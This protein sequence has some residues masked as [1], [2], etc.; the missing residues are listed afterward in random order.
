MKR[1]HCPPVLLSA[2]ATL[3]LSGTALAA[4]HVDIVATGLNNPRGLNFAPN[5]ELYV[6]EAGSGGDGRCIPAPDDPSAQTLL[7]GNGCAHHHL[8][9]GVATEKSRAP[10]SMAGPGGFAASS[11]PVD[12][13]F[14]GM[15]AFVCH[16]LGRRPCPALRR[17]QKRSAF[18]HSATST[19]RRHIRAGGRHFRR[20][21]NDS[22]QPAGRSTPIRMAPLRCQA[23]AS[24]DAGANCADRI[25]RLARRILPRARSNTCGIAA[26]GRRT[27]GVP[28]TVVEGPDGDLMWGTHGS[29][30]PARNF[31]Y[32]LF[33]P[34]GGTPEVYLAGLTAVVDIAFD[35]RG[36]LYILEIAS[37]LQCW[38]ECRSGCRKRTPA[39]QAARC[40]NR[41]RLARQP[42]VSKW[43]C[44][45]TGQRV[46]LTNYGIFPDGGEVLRG[47]SR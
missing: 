30:V 31:K 18:R 36:D 28:T 22:I 20:M 32:L 14:I 26:D 4:T 27:R 21:R 35:R 15:S 34:Q 46:Y 16:G 1:L 24:A 7:W 38:A 45:R 9:G 11:G 42:R 44:D 8:S 40:R 6:A 17:R 23:G 2:F 33:P 10:T 29:A 41:R 13:D 12:V 37:G 47:T 43:D 25:A 5:G 39:A 19:A 3:A